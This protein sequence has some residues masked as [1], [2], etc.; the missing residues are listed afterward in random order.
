MYRPPQHEV[1]DTSESPSRN[2][3]WLRFSFGQGWRRGTTAGLKR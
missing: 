3:S 1:A 2:G